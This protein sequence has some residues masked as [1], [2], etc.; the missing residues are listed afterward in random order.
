[1]F[2]FFKNS[3]RSADVISQEL[4][5]HSMTET[6]TRQKTYFGGILSIIVVFLGL[7]VTGYF[8]SFLFLKTDPKAF[9][10]TKYSDDT[11]K[12]FFDNSEF[13]FIMQVW[14]HLVNFNIN[15]TVV[16][17][18]GVQRTNNPYS[19]L[20]T[21]YFEKCNYDRDFQGMEEV[22]TRDHKDNYEQTWWCI[23]GMMENET[24]IPKNDP[25]Y[26]KPYTQ[27]GMSSKSQNPIYFEIQGQRCINSTANNFSCMPKEAVDNI[28]QGGSY[29]IQFADN[30]FDPS[31]YDQPISQYIH[32]IAGAASPTNLA[33]NYMNINNVDF[34]THD[35]LIFDNA[36][37]ILSYQFSDRVEI[38]TPNSPGEYDNIFFFFRL[39]SHCAWNDHTIKKEQSFNPIPP[40]GIFVC[41]NMVLLQYL[42][43][44]NQELQQGNIRGLCFAV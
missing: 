8:L 14:S 31:N 20:G 11:E 23:V 15:D 27:H 25:R 9:Q 21:Y 4:K 29:T 13:F 16:K 33:S 7:A 28:L 1:M 43:P 42:C 32:Q 12:I 17:I 26:R 22:F 35:G 34:T 44:H 37:T 10:V 18:V 19:T 40:H 41:Q 3:L 30:F 5:L 2:K 24:I 36:N 38:V 39:E 6:G